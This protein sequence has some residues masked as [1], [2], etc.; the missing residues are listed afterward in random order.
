MKIHDL[1]VLPI[2]PPLL[3]EARVELIKPAFAALFV[4]AVGQSFTD[5]LPVLCAVN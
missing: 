5:L 2:S 1:P 3:D 4:D